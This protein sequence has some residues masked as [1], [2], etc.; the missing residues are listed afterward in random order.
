MHKK[1]IISVVVIL[2]LIGSLLI[3][4]T[5]Y[6]YHQTLLGDQSRPTIARV[7]SGSATIVR[8]D[9]AYDLGSGEEIELQSLDRVLCR[10]DSR[11]TILWSDQSI[12]R[13][14]SKSEITIQELSVNRDLSEVGIS[15]SL[16]QGRIWTRVV[17]T[18]FGDSHFETSL[19]DYQVTAAI[20]GTVYEIDRESGYIH[21]VE[22]MIELSDSSNK[23]KQLLP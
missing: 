17:R 3:G 2:F 13:L 21:G 18:L 22:H 4:Y 7:E 15:F 5:I 10:E 16:D 8:G 1:I 9:T 14:G 23:K 11:T 19:P 6:S 12:S 20:R